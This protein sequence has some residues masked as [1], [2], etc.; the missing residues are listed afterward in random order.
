MSDR[1]D[2]RIPLMYRPAQLGPD[3]GQAISTANNLLQFRQNQQQVQRQN[4][5]RNILGTPGAIDA[6][7]NPTPETLTKVM[8]VDPDAGLKL[9]QNALVTQQRKLQMDAL[10]TKTAFDNASYLNDAY[11]PILEQY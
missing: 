2:A 11:A 5:L 4:A 9:Q 6:T 1:V 10:T 8:G 3:I 7:G